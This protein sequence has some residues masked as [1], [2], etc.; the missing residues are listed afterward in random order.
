MVWGRTDAAKLSSANN[1]KNVLK[2]K[3]ER[4][5][6]EKQPSIQIISRN[7]SDRNYCYVIAIIF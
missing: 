4:K 6:E 7:K 5:K 3:G 1:D 2:E